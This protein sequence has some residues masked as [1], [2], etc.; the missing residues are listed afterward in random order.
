MCNCCNYSALD[1]LLNMSFEI[2]VKNVLIL[3]EGKQGSSRD[4]S[5]NIYLFAN[6][7]KTDLIIITL[8]FL[9]EHPVH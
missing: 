8:F 6:I 4:I 7:T 1:E 2:D 3:F 9:Q 5:I